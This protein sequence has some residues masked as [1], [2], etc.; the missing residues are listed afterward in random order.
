MSNQM[1]KLSIKNAKDTNIELVIIVRIDVTHKLLQFED[2][3]PAVT[4]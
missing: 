2:V 1:T 3:N 4:L